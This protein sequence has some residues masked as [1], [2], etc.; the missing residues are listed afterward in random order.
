MPRYAQKSENLL[1]QEN[2]K[3]GLKSKKYSKIKEKTTMIKILF[4]CHGR[5]KVKTA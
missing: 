2:S 5:S 1:Y 3:N 4:V